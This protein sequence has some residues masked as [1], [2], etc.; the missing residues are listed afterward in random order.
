MNV[1]NYKDNFLEDILSKKTVLKNIN[2]LSAS[3]IPKTLPHREEDF[4]TLARQFRYFI[5][6]SNAPSQNVIITGPTGSG[7]TTL[8]RRFETMINSIKGQL[9]IKVIYI[10]SRI[11]KSTYLLMNTLVR[12]L[13]P[14]IPPRGYSFE[15]L[16]SLFIQLLENTKTKIILIL[17]EVDYLISRIGKDFLYTLLRINEMT[18]NSWMSFIFVARNLSF[19]RLLDVSTQSSLSSYNLPLSKYS[20]EAILDILKARAQEAFFEGTVTDDTFELISDI[21]SNSG[22]A[23]YA[24]ELL[25]GAAQCADDEMSPIVYPDHVRRAKSLIHPELR[26]EALSALSLHEHLVLLGIIRK[27][28]HTKKAYLTT[29]E[30]ISGYIVVC[31]EYNQR[32]RKHTQL[33]SY[34]KEL[35]KQDIIQ[36]KI[37]GKGMHGKTTLVSFPDI[38]VKIIEKFV[39]KCIIEHF[40]RD[41]D[42]KLHHISQQDEDHNE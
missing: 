14:A 38:S 28:K 37:S 12:S 22:D 41:V 27:L 1:E 26:T 19:I 40:K 6:S 35:S 39:E 34:I 29:S 11:Y 42:K 31:E 25:W 13:Q 3:Y 15:E 33:W 18:S 21:V 30:V 5:N 4:R 20:R 32:P 16:H 17:D 9:Q 24:I 10:N 2:A 23:R 36:T 7:K 8:A